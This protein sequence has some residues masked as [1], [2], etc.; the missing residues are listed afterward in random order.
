M[1]V[2]R[3]QLEIRLRA[4]NKYT[5][6]INK[7]ESLQRESIFIRYGDDYAVVLGSVRKAARTPQKDDPGAEVA[8][9]SWCPGL[10]SEGTTKD[11]AL[12]VPVPEAVDAGVVFSS[13]PWT[14]IDAMPKNEETDRNGFRREVRRVGQ[15]NS[16]MVYWASGHILT[17]SPNLP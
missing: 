2:A 13:K 4:D 12:P 17:A 1:A 3:E 5:D 6:A 8:S 7:L 14:T 15:W 16:E 11:G 9:H 10:A